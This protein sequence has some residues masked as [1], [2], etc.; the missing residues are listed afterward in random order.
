LEIITKK[1]VLL[2]G[3]ITLLANVSFAQEDNTVTLTVSGQG[4]TQDEAKQNA[5]RNAIEQA[6]GTFISSNTEILNDELV[7]DEIVSVANGNIQKFEVI[8]E[9]QI[10]DGGYNTTLKVTVSVAKLTTFVE[11]KGVVVEFKGGLFAS[12]ILIQ[13]LYEKNE[14]EA[15]SNIVTILKEISKKSFDYSINVEEPFSKNEI[16]NIPITVNVSVNSNFMNIP[17]LLEQTIKSIGL[18]STELENYSKLNKPVFPITLATLESKGIYYLRNE[19][20]IISIIDFI[21][22]LNNSIVG[23]DVFNGIEKNHLSKYNI[24]SQYSRECNC[25]ISNLEIFDDNFR[26]ILKN[27]NNGG[28]CFI[29]AASLFHNFCGSGNDSKIPVFDYKSLYMD[30]FSYSIEYDDCFRNFLNK[31]SNFY[32]I[33]FLEKKEFPTTHMVGK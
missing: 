17:S 24:G 29:C 30:G 7:K 20:S 10:P 16:W 25:R 26:I 33:E 22:S 31:S 1:I 8:S 4:Q 2:L 21:Y 27:R 19:N 15:I 13:K 28:W 6:F 9:V 5:L 18:S 3:I 32:I 14:T 12:N 23:F 11:S